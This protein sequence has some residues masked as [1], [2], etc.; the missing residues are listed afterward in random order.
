VLLVGFGGVKNSCRRGDAAVAA[1]ICVGQSASFGTVPSSGDDGAGRSW[2][3]RGRLRAAWRKWVGLGIAA[4]GGGQQVV[5]QVERRPG[6][7]R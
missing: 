2:T 1:A 5:A 3:V 6:M 7:R 4:I